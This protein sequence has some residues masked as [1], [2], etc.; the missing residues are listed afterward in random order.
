MKNILIGLM[1]LISMGCATTYIVPT[2]SRIYAPDGQ[3]IGKIKHF[4]THSRIYD[5]RG[6]YKC[7]IKHY[8]TPADVYDSNGRLIYRTQ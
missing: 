3:Y 7:K 1:F 4:K 6:R 8:Q 2:T 5:D